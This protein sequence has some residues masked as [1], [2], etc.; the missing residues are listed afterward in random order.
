[1]QLLAAVSL[2]TFVQPEALEAE[3][4]FRG[5][6]AKITA[7]KALKMVCK[8]SVEMGANAY[9]VDVTLYAAGGNRLR[10]Q[11]VPT[12]KTKK[13]E[14]LLVVADGK[15]IGVTLSLKG[16]TT[17]RDLEGE[18]N[19]K[20]VDLLIRSGVGTALDELLRPGSQPSAEELVL[21]NFKLGAKEKIDNKR[22]VRIID[23]EVGVKEKA[24]SIKVKLWLDTQALLPVRRVSTL[25]A[26]TTEA[27]YAEVFT[28]FTTDAKIDAKLF[29][30]PK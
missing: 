29:E 24:G 14:E 21:S 6:E 22:E 17:V 13:E 5:M 9:R 4:L 20:L 3:K 11:A 2:L 15:K 8:T 1:M 7:A 26:G 18:Y 23:Y 28:E 30:L 16:E 19:Q 25:V 10:V 27:R 12:T